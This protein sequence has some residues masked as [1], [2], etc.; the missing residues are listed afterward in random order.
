VEQSDKRS[1]EEEMRL[2]EEAERESSV[3]SGTPPTHK[4]KCD[5]PCH[6]SLSLNHTF[7]HERGKSKSLVRISSSPLSRLSSDDREQGPLSTQ[8][9][10]PHFLET[11]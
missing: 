7:P 4:N 11:L 3:Q 5:F 8:R 10:V 2:R 9:L 6:I 1:R